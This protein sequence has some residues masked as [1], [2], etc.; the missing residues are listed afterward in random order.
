MPA[1]DPSEDIG[2]LFRSLASLGTKEVAVAREAIMNEL[3]GRGLKLSNDSQSTL[4]ITVTLSE[5]FQQLIWVA[6]IQ[7]NQNCTLVMTSHERLP[8]MTV[9][10]V[11]I[12]TKLLF[13]QDDPILDIRLLDDE[14][15]VL[16]SRQ[17]ALYSRQNDHWHLEQSASLKHSR[18]FP[19]D[20]RGRLF[21]AGDA[22][23]VHLPGLSCT[24]SVK[25]VFALNCTQGETPWPFAFGGLA[26]TLS[27]N[28]FVQENFPAFYSIAP[29]EDEG[30]ELL[31]ITGID[32]R[33]YLLDK[34]SGKTEAIDG[35]SSDITAI[36]S[37]CGAPCHILATIPTDPL[38]RSV[39]KAFEITHRKAV[40]T[41]AVVEFPGPITALWP[42]PDRKAAIAIARDLKT[43]RY[44]AFSLSLSYSR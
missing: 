34:A 27:K 44:A 21:D 7:R 40:A 10:W 36:D 24:G 22:I 32:G 28:Y 5:S 8:K 6:E 41:G 4:T 11:S 14:L 30:T 17:L 33:A 18:P 42:E 29:V 16:D 15:L 2:F 20:T 13:E 25:P 39:I 9:E 43:G 23:Q 19:R 37:G 35:W 1:V 38:E 26:P 12:R 3:H 31:A